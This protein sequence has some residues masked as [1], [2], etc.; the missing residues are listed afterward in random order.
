MHEEGCSSTRATIPVEQEK[1]RDAEI[2]DLAFPEL[3]DKPNHPKSFSFPNES[4]GTKSQPI[5]PFSLHGSRSGHGLLTTKWMIKRFALFV[6][7]RY[8]RKGCGIVH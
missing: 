5:A 1:D 8:N 3:G 4:L 2:H 6:L 7:R